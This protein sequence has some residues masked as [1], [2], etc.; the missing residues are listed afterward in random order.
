MLDQFVIS[1]TQQAMSLDSLQS[2]HPIMSDVKNPSEIEAIFDA[3]SYKKV[4]FLNLC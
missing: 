1:T 2:S 3:I 4:F